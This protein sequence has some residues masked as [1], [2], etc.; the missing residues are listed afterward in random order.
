[1]DLKRRLGIACC[2]AI[3]IA[4]DQVVTIKKCKAKAD[5]IKALWREL[6]WLRDQSGFGF[7]DNTRLVTAR[8]TAWKDI[9]KVISNTFNIN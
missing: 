8:E 5:A 4:R 6:N 1:M 3:N 9:I 2:T 7:D